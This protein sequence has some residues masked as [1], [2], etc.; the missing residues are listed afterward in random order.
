MA[1]AADLA[2]E[3]LR[4]ARDDEMAARTLAD[5]AE[6]SDAIVAFH[7]QQAAEKAMK[8]VLAAEA[9]DFPFTHDLAGLAELCGGVGRPI[10]EQLR[11]IDRRSPYGAQL[12]YGRPRE[13][14]IERASALEL[15]SGAIAWAGDQLGTR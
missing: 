11:E 4:L 9:V 2:A 6:V 12:R 14:G 3:L 1:S 8:A 7:C 15:A 13:G 10:P 5:S